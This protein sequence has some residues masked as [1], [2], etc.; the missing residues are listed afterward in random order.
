ML[1]LIEFSPLITAF[2]PPAMA[3]IMPLIKSMMV[4]TVFFTKS[5]M[6]VNVFSQDFCTQASAVSNPF[7]TGSVTYV[8][9]HQPAM[10]QICLMVSQVL[11]P[12]ADTCG[13]ASLNHFL[14]GSV[15]FVWNHAPAL[16]QVL[17]I[18]SQHSMALALAISHACGSTW[19]ATF[20]RFSA[21]VTLPICQTM[22]F[23]THPASGCKKFFHSQS[24]IGWNATRAVLS[25]S[26]AAV[27]KSKNFGSRSVIVHAPN[28]TRIL[29]QAHF[30]PAQI[31]S[32]SGVS[33]TTNR[34][35]ASRTGCKKSSI[36][37]FHAATFAARAVM[38]ASITEEA[39]FVCEIT[40][41][42]PPA[43]PPLPPDPAA[44][45]V[46]SAV[47]KTLN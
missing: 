23:P 29:S 44:L 24:P 27:N 46:V 13:Q 1:T 39:S 12:N 25:K 42:P 36:C 4:L 19:I 45:A 15:T 28:G 37:A 14:I 11:A 10:A 17:T 18:A 33:A 35:K 22:L 3:R 20:S 21:Q 30:N 2:I 43:P 7:L 40:P 6:P 34:S 8:E 38:A 9:N 41:P 26:V 47:C 31:V 32:P 5:L 16:Y